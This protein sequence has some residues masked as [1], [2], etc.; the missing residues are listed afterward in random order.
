MSQGG[1]EPASLE[2][3]RDEV[4]RI[5]SEENVIL[6]RGGIPGGTGGTVVVRGAIKKKNAGRV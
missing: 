6:V 3:L 5:V 1:P 2:S 4:V